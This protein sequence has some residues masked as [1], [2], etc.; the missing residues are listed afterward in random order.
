MTQDVHHVPDLPVDLVP[1][2]KLMR[3]EHDGWYQINGM[4][5]EMVFWTGEVVSTPF[6][7]VT[8][9]PM[10]QSFLDAGKVAQMFETSLY[11]CVTKEGNN[12]LTCSQKEMLRW[13]WRMGHPGMALVKWLVCRGLLG[14]ASKQIKGVSDN[15]HPLCAS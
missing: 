9:L 7:P 8:S 5:A 1:P 4:C 12:N 10:I 13:H 11:S 14:P 3:T 2:Q 15:D 6:D